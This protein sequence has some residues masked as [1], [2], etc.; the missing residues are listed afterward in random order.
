M[1]HQALRVARARYGTCDASV[2]DSA[3]QHVKGFSLLKCQQKLTAGYW[4]VAGA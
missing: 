1:Q 4:G 2:M 3:R